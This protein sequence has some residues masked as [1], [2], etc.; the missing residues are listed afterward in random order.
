MSGQWREFDAIRRF[1]DL[2]E[3]ASL[4]RGEGSVHANV[5]YI[6]VD[7]IDPNPHQMRVVFDI[8]D[9]VQSV[10]K[11]GVIEPIG[12]VP[13]QGRYQLVFGERRLRAAKEVGLR[14]V[15]CVVFED[16]DDAVQAEISY[17]ENVHR[18]DLAPAERCLAVLGLIE[19]GYSPEEV[20]ELSAVTVQYV[21]QMIKA[22]RWLREVVDLLGMEKAAALFSP[23]LEMTQLLKLS[24]T[25]SPERAVE[26]LERGVRAEVPRRPHLV[27]VK[28]VKQQ[29]DDLVRKVS[30][31]V[32]RDITEEE[33]QVLLEVSQV[34]EELRKLLRRLLRLGG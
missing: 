15:P 21:Y 3:L 34:V 30:G 28:R 17:I 23:E 26:A 25:V 6:P 7:L 12:V 20:A 29:V 2:K 19:R 31:L 32:E 14:E 11:R 22:G 4:V 16:V 18:K 27:S 13:R 1:K 24:R 8:S 33:R 5:K 10:K 9:L